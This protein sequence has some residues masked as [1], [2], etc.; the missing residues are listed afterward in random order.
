MK[1]TNKFNLPDP[2]VNAV[3]NT[4][5]TPG[6][7][8][9]TVTQLIQP[10]LIRKLRIEHDD[11]IEE[12]ASDRVWALFGTA[13]HHLLEMAYKGS[14][15]RQEERVY[16]EVSG[17]K[18][19]GAFDV[20]EGSSLSDYKVTSIY[21]S[22]GKIEWERQLN[23]LRW[24]LHK[25]GTEVTKLSI[26]AIFRDWRP[27]ERK[28]MPDYPARPIMVLPIKM[29]TLDEAEAYIKERVALHQLADPPICTD[30]DRWTVPEKWA[31]M[32]KGAKK[33]IKLY[34]SK[35]GVI[36][37]PDQFWEHRPASYRRCEDY[38]SVSKWC[39][40]WNDTTF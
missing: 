6:S 8:D 29:W 32:K 37:N 16:A 33:A 30:E 21:S 28:R 1:L 13:V 22:N 26:T 14:T 12:D 35:E 31:V 7:S 18:L 15:A 9:I 39:K 36:L 19:G 34:Q 38:C 23:V 11:D 27:M 20:L 17:W 4:G 3:N 10:P 2:I 5:Y 25:N 40:V 24:L